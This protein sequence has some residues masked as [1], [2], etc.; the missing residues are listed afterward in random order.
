M[1]KELGAKEAMLR[2][3]REAK[4][5]HQI[6]ARPRSRVQKAASAPKRRGRP[7]KAAKA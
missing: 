1:A 4:A 7:A 2:A 5:E 6:R 3:Q